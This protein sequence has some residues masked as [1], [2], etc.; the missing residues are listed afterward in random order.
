[1]VRT[2]PHPRRSRTI[3]IEPEIRV[4]DKAIVLPCGDL[5]K[6]LFRDGVRA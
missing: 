1:M 5:G 6:R 4:K 3:E 2:Q